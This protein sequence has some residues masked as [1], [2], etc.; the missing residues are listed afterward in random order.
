MEHDPITFGDPDITDVEFELKKW[1]ADNEGRVRQSM[2]RDLVRNH[3]ELFMG[4]PAADV[5]ETLVSDASLWY[6][7][8]PSKEDFGCRL[9][10]RGLK[11]Q[12][13]IQFNVKDGR[14]IGYVANVEK[15]W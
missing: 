8:H 10:R 4:Q 9:A 2:V 11:Y 13:C 15:V 6:W 5:K 14:V 12:N 1:Q 3:K 7:A